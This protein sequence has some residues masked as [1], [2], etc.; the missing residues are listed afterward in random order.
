MR[1]E[2]ASNILLRLS[3]SDVVPNGV[4]DHINAAKK[5]TRPLCN[6][7]RLEVQDQAQAWASAFA[8]AVDRRSPH[9]VLSLKTV[10]VIKA[11]KLEASVA[12][13]RIKE[14]RVRTGAMPPEGKSTKAPTKSA[15][16]WVRGTNGWRQSHIGT[17]AQIDEVPMPDD[18]ASTGGY[19]DDS[20]IPASPSP[21]S[22]AV[23]LS[24]Q[25]EVNAEAN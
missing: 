6:S 1:A 17:L 2:E 16:R 20:I 4:G 9:W 15:Y 19:G 8:N 24:D 7:A 5:A 13:S 3:A 10:A 22:D 14:W 18:E 25:A 12:S 23:P 21:S 11:S